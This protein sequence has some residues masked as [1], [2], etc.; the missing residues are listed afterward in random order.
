VTVVSAYR[1]A[2]V[3][4]C[5][6]ICLVL[7]LGCSSSLPKPKAGPVP[8]DALIEVPY[9]PPAARVEDIPKQAKPSDVWIDGQWDWTGRDWRWIDGAW[10]TP[11]AADAYFTPWTT[12]RERNGHLLFAPAAWRAKDGRPLETGWG[13]ETCA[14]PIAAAK[15]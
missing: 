3:P 2:G 14:L 13:R 1:A 4:T 15:P 11:P 8:D 10:M 12:K 7:G 6:A 5:A 9:P